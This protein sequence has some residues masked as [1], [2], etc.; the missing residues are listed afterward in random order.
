MHGGGGETGAVDV[1]STPLKTA[2]AAIRQASSPGLRWYWRG[3]VVCDAAAALRDL[4]LGVGFVYLVWGRPGA[5]EAVLSGL[6]E[7]VSPGVDVTEAIR[8]EVPPQEPEW[9]REEALHATL[10]APDFQACW[11]RID[12]GDMKN[13]QRIA[14]L[15]AERKRLQLLL[16]EQSA[17]LR[18]RLDPQALAAYGSSMRAWAA[19]RDRRCELQAARNQAPTPRVNEL[20]C[21]NELT[22]KFIL[23]LR[24][25]Y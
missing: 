10:K 20:F 24:M 21:V 17:S 4:A 3:R 2:D 14:C 1:A 22:K 9:N 25:T 12:L 19:W 18:Q 8:H 11:D 6:H 16:D 15:H 7:P 5:T 13:S 23:K